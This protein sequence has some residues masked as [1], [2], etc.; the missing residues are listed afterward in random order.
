MR[1][2]NMPPQVVR[3]V[4][5]TIGILGSYLVARAV[6]T[7]A[8]FGDYGWYRGKALEEIASRQNTYAGKVACQEC[9]SDQVQKLTKHEHKTLSCEGCHGAGQAH[10]DN[11]DVKME[12]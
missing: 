5:L 3:L 2:F 7:P 1:R 9:H 6:L 8:S 4:L 11:P 10:A 12:I